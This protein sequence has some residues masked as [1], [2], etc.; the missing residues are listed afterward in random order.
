MYSL[1]SKYDS[2]IAFTEEIFHSNKTQDT[3]MTWNSFMTWEKRIAFYS[4]WSDQKL[5]I[6][7]EMKSK[8]HLRAILTKRPSNVNTLEMKCFFLERCT[9]RFRSR[10]SLDDGSARFDNNGVC[11]CLS[12]AAVLSALTH[13][14]DE[15]AG[16]GT[17]IDETASNPRDNFNISAPNWC[18]AVIVD[19]VGSGMLFIERECTFLIKIKLQKF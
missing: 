5:N 10:D 14:V 7:K 2:N 19:G 17:T 3:N 13:V 15:L 11:W 4:L 12:S 9:Y 18:N 1:W 16:M 6:E 8:C